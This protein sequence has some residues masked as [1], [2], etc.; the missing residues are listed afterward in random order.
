MSVPE[1]T[2]YK[3]LAIQQADRESRRLHAL[4]TAWELEG[5]THRKEFLLAT[6]DVNQFSEADHEIKFLRK[7]IGHCAV[8]QL[9]HDIDHHTWVYRRDLTLL[10][11]HDQCLSQME[12]AL[13]RREADMTKDDLVA[14]IKTVVNVDDTDTEQ[15]DEDEDGE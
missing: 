15:S 7:I 10:A 6:K 8:R 3:A 14:I 13:E 4:A 11:L 5:L 2:F 1:S 12:E 9:E